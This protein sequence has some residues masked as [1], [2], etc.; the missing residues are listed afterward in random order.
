MNEEAEFKK[1]ITPE[2]LSRLV[3]H[4]PMAMWIS[5]TNGETFWLNTHWHDAYEKDYPEGRAHSSG[6][7]DGMH[8]EHDR[9][10]QDAFRQSVKEL[11]PFKCEYQ[12]PGTDDAPRWVLN[13]ATPSWDDTGDFAGYCGAIIDISERVGFV[14]SST[15]C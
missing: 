1:Q 11:K 14:R 15:R 8:A 4:I 9:H 5:D 6:W 7:F 10:V 3:K 13:S 12:V 2:N